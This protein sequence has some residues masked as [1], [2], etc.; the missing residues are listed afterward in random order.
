[1]L[2][3]LYNMK[4]LITIPV[5]LNIYLGILMRPSGVRTSRIRTS[6]CEHPESEHPHARTSGTLRRRAEPASMA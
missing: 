5:Y 4:Y 3:I 1:M 2:Y 6:V